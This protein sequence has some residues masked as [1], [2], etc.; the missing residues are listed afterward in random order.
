MEKQKGRKGEWKRRWYK[1]EYGKT[2]SQERRMEKN[3]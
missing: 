1:E 3:I 2:E